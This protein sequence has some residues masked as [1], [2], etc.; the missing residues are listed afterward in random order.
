M[1]K[2]L[3]N[4]AQNCELLA[5]EVFIKYGIFFFLACKIESCDALDK[6]R[7]SSCCFYFTTLKLK[8][9][10]PSYP[11]QDT[12]SQGDSKKGVTWNKLVTL[13]RVSFQVALEN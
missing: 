11:V 5:L 2:A 4:I 3:L 7:L 1:S 13:W 9:V 8:D 6:H 10:Q 12:S